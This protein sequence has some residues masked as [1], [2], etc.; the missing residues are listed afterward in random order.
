M[1]TTANDAII[2]TQLKT[3]LATTSVVGLPL[4]VVGIV[5]GTNEAT[6]LS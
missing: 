2:E 6:T 3:T 5:A 4:V 1:V